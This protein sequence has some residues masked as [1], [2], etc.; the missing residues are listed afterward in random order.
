MCNHSLYVLYLLGIEVL[1]Q[2]TL[3]KKLHIFKLI[4]N[5]VLFG[6]KITLV[7]C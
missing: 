5:N 3:E 7:I 6:H 2:L 4:S 1:L